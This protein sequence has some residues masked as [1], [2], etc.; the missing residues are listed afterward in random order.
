MFRCCYRL[1]KVWFAILLY[2]WLQP[3]D[4]SAQDD[5]YS[6]KLGKETAFLGAGTALSI[7]GWTMTSQMAPPDTNLL[8]VEN[9]FFFDRLAAGFHD[10]TTDVISD[11]TLLT[12]L[13]LPAVS[14]LSSNSSAEVREG[15]ILYL[16]SLLITEGLTNITK[17]LFRRARPYTYGT[18]YKLTA[19]SGRSFFSGHTSMAFTGAMATGL[20]L[21]AYHGDSDWSTPLWAAGLSLATA[22]GFFRVTSGNHFPTDV[23]VGALVGGLTTYL[24]IEA[25]R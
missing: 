15:L 23:L 10:Q 12:C 17:A 6:L 2:I 11:V 19:D 21:D 9:V 14:L 1:N 5:V 7:L 4:L 18:G 20:L 13:C 8:A 16:E 3:V 25:H 22:T 24:V